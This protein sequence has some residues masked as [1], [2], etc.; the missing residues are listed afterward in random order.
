MICL[1]LSF[2]PFMMGGV[3]AESKM[4]SARSLSLTASSRA[5]DW[6]YG[7]FPEPENKLLLHCYVDL[8]L[9]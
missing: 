3:S 9:L 2:H 4:L 6:N 5:Q 7:I 8:E 1:H